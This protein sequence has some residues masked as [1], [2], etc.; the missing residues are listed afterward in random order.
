[1]KFK[2]IKIFSIQ[3]NL[4]SF[5]SYVIC[6]AHKVND[7]EI[8]GES[9]LLTIYK[10]KKAKLIAMEVLY[11]TVDVNKNFTI[12]ELFVIEECL[13]QA[14]LNI[15]ESKVGHYDFATLPF[16]KN[17][18]EVKIEYLLHGIFSPEA[19]QSKIKDIARLSKIEDLNKLIEIA[20]QHKHS[21]FTHITTDSN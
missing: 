5:P 21:L 8:R 20:S 17:V 1:M 12:D 13:N 10:G 2:N 11:N 9:F 14:K 3:S 6:A 15:L 18:C 16:I 7:H 19:I 4:S